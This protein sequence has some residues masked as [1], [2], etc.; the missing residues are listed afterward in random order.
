M[1]NMNFLIVYVI[2]FVFGIMITFSQGDA[3]KIKS[4]QFS[5]FGYQTGSITDTFSELPV[6]TEVVLLKTCSQHFELFLYCKY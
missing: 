6:Y 5:E 3:T 2:Q 1:S 4:K